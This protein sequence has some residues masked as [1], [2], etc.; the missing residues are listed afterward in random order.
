[1][2]WMDDVIGGCMRTATI[3]AAGNGSSMFLLNLSGHVN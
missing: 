1:M 3:A 2:L